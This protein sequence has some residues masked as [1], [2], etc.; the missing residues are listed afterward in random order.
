M[1]CAATFEAKPT[2]GSEVVQPYRSCDSHI[3]SGSVVRASWATPR[4]SGLREGAE[5]QPLV[6]APPIKV[7]ETT[8]KDER[9][10]RCLRTPPPQQGAR[11]CLQTSSESKFQVPRCAEDDPGVQSR[12]YGRFTSRRVALRPREVSIATT[13]TR[14]CFDGCGARR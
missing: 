8:A 7:M 14:G 11:H 6:A 10:T 4:S 2:E 5:L 13:C 3:A 1:A 12:L 9:T